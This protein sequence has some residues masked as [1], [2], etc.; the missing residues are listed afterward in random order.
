M[1]LH[2]FIGLFCIL[3]G[4]AFIASAFYLQKLEDRKR[5][6]GF[7]TTA[8]IVAMKPHNDQA[9]T[10]VTFELTKDFQIR[11]VTNDF[12]AEEA[13]NWKVGRRSLVVYDEDQENI[14]QSHAQIQKCSG[15][16][17][18]GWIRRLALWRFLDDLCQYVITKAFWQTTAGCAKGVYSV[19]GCFT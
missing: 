16:G 5:M 7:Y 12:S 18:G 19:G 4:I 2:T 10:R 8:T 3:G 15:L 11:Q 6:P 17:H 1:I 14:F 9:K 13:E